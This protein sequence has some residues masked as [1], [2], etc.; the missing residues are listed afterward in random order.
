MKKEIVFIDE[1][2]LTPEEWEAIDDEQT[3][4]YALTFLGIDCLP[5]WFLAHCC[6]ACNNFLFKHWSATMIMEK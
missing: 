2:T 3:D 6:C 4:E 1:D 5:K